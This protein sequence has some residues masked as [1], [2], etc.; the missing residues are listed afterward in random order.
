MN[1]KLSKRLV[2]EMLVSHTDSLMRDQP[3]HLDVDNYPDD[4]SRLFDLSGQLYETLHPIQPSREFVSG[5]N[6]RLSD[7]WQLTMS[8]RKRLVQLIRTMGVIT[9]VLIVSALAT[10]L[11]G[12]VITSLT[13]SKTQHIDEA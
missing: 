12:V 1:G 2:E 8:Q 4:V 7:G 9:S 11:I 10:Q 5:L 6:S 13:R 3:S